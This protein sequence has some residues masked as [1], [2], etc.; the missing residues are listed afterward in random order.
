MGVLAA[1]G[2]SDC[3]T[4]KD[5]L[6]KQQITTSASQLATWI[7]LVSHCYGSMLRMIPCVA[8]MMVRETQRHDRFK[9]I[10]AFRFLCINSRVVLL[11]LA[12]VGGCWRLL[13]VVGGCWR[14]WWKIVAYK[15]VDWEEVHRNKNIITLV[16]KRGGHV[17][18]HA[19][20]SPTGL[21]FADNATLQFLSSVLQLQAESRCVLCPPPRPP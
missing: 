18:W 12:V 8:N 2:R 13:A 6:K 9:R 4:P 14:W 21:T 17:Q 15:T 20:L 16:T 7:K 1:V 19:G 3:C 5:G 10:S 11:L